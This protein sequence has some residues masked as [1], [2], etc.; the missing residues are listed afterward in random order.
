[1]EV[2]IV[3]LD[4]H[5]FLSISNENRTS[6]MKVHGLIKTEPEGSPREKLYQKDTPKDTKGVNPGGKMNLVTVA[7]YRRV[8]S[9]VI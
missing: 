5:L 8:P 9:G 2:V 1:M 3:S 6:P 7:S 4:D